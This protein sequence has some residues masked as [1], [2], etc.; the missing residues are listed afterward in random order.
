MYVARSVLLIASS[1]PCFKTTY[2]YVYVS[3]TTTC[4]SSIHSRLLPFAI[5]QSPC[6]PGAY[7]SFGGERNVKIYEMQKYSRSKQQQTIFVEY[8]FLE[9]PA[10]KKNKKNRNKISYVRISETLR[11]GRKLK[12]S[13]KRQKQLVC[14]SF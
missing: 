11:P 6:G 7:T 9:E 5:I 1:R 10:E 13:K 8:I 4:I 14:C 12:S 2:D 3:S